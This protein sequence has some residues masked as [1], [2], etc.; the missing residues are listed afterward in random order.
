MR[1]KCVDDKSIYFNCKA[2][3]I[4]KGEIYIVVKENEKHYDI[5]NDNGS[6]ETRNKDRFEI[7]EG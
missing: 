5:I 6:V 7:V 4:T 2:D 3:G 1:V